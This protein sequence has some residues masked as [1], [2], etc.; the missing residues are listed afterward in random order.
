MNTIRKDIDEIYGTPDEKLATAQRVLGQEIEKELVVRLAEVQLVQ[1]ADLELK[2]LIALVHF[3]V[4]E[5]Q[6]IFLVLV[7]LVLQAVL[8]F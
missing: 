6:I 7:L 8:V 1:L 4:L 5:E 3:L 2:Y